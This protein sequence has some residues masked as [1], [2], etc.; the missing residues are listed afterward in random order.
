MKY[1][2]SPNHIFKDNYDEIIKSAKNIRTFSTKKFYEKAE[3]TNIYVFFI[4]TWLSQLWV[5]A[6][7]KTHGLPFRRICANNSM[8]PGLCIGGSAILGS[9]YSST[10]GK[11]AVERTVTF[12]TSAA[13]QPSWQ[14]SHCLTKEALLHVQSGSLACQKCHFCVM[15]WLFGVPKL[16]SSKCHGDTWHA[17]M[18]KTRRKAK[19][20]YAKARASETHNALNFRLIILRDTFFS[21]SLQKIGCD[22]VIETSFITLALHY[23]CRR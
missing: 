19:V 13:V 22:S 8:H 16:T 2:T 10:D 9:Q 12:K 5:S 23:L 7:K 3:D 18:R 11:T 4:T 15:K 14:C 17:D 21:L 20:G 1:G 6:H